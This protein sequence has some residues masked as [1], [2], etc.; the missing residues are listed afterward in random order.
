VRS[1][2]SG[3]LVNSGHLLENLVFMALR[4]MTPDIH[5]YKT[6]NGREVDFIMGR[7]GA[8]RMLVQVC[9]SMASDQTRKREVAALGEAMAELQLIEGTMVTRHEE[10]RISVASG[11]I[12]IMPVWR[13]LLQQ[14][15]GRLQQEG[16]RW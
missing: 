1:I 13:F 7:A 5:Y 11:T 15:G 14:E 4:R 16:G 3:I 12:T 8:S 9:E 6:R 10:G 2:N